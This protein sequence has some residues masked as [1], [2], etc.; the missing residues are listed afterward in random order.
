MNSELRFGIMARQDLRLCLP[1]LRELPF[2]GRSDAAVE[3]LAAASQQSV[4]R[5]ILNERMLE[6]VLHI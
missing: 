2:H 4:V 6:G 5:S 3:L 1:D